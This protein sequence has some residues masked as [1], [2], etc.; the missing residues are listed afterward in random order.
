MRNTDEDDIEYHNIGVQMALNEFVIFND[1]ETFNRVIK[2]IKDHPEYDEWFITQVRSLTL[3]YTDDIEKAAAE[4]S[5]LIEGFAWRFRH[6]FDDEDMFTEFKSRFIEHQTS[7]Y[8]EVH[9]D[10][11]E[12]L[13]SMKSLDKQ[14]SDSLTTA[15]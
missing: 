2:E 11:T 6:Y 7:F 4:F 12:M 3:A 5:V 9:A 1:E 8:K 15:V 14:I 10:L 13:D